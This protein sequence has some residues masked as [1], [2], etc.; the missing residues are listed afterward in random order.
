MTA[1]SSAWAVRAGN[2]SEMGRPDSPCWRK[3]KEGAI[4]FAS[5]ILMNW[6]F[7]LSDRKLSGKRVAIETL[8]GRLRVEAVHLA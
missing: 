3:A 1:S 6:A 2:R 8:E 7:R 4:S 5:E